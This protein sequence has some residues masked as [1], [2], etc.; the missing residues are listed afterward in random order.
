MLFRIHNLLGGNGLLN[1]F[2]LSRE[3]GMVWHC[4][5]EW[6][7]GTAVVGISVTEDEID[8]VL[9]RALDLYDRCVDVA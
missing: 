9:R 2:K 5:L 1:E 3:Q 8:A 7:E 6:V 4:R